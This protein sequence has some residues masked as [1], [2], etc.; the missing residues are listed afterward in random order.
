MSLNRYN[1]IFMLPLLLFSLIGC[2]TTGYS[3]KTSIVVPKTIR[4]PASIP[5]EL[6]PY[7]PRFVELLQTKGFYVGRTEDPRALDLV[8]EFNGNPFNLRVSAGLWREGI[9]ILSASATN[10]GWGTAL[11]RGSAVNS[12]ADSAVATFEAEL[13]NL[14]T[15]TQIVPDGQ[16]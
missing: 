4:S 13:Q 7:V 10:S 16:H 6:I 8:F 1:I 14:V 15:H 11:A 12:L 5:P 9:P 2:S 3:T